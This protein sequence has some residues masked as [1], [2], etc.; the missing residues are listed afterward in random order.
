M[1]YEW[2]PAKSA[3]N[4]QKHGVDFADAVIALEDERAGTI[5]APH[6]ESE[7]RFVSLGMDPIGRILVT[8]FAYRDERIRVIS[9]RTAT[10][11]ER[12][13]YEESL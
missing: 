5:E 4:L 9:S 1:N 6:S 8:I 2:D 10:K 7:Q 12:L 13:R 11:K 3:S